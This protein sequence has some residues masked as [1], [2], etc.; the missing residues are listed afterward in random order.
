LKEEG[1]TGAQLQTLVEYADALS[2][3]GDWRGALE[4]IQRERA[5]NADVEKRSNDAV[6]KEMQS[7]Y[8]A[9]AKQRGIEILGRENAL[10]TAALAN[11]DLLQ[12]IGLII[13][14]VLAATLVLATV[15]YRRVRSTQS[16]LAQGHAKLKE[17]SERDPLTNLANRRRF[18]AL[19]QALHGPQSSQG[20]SGGLL[21]VD[22]DHFKRIN[23]GH[24]HAAGDQVLTE[25][26]KRLGLAVESD[27]LVV[28]W[29]GEE[30][31]VHATG[32]DAEQ[33]DRLAAR[34]L[35]ELGNTAVRVDGQALRI[36]ASVGHG[37]FPL[38]PARVP[39]SWEQAVNLCDMALYAAKGG[40]RNRSVGIVSV[41]VSESAQLRDIERDFEQARQAGRVT[42]RVGLG[43]AP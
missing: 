39:L 40:G 18:H 25:V 43:P 37:C 3:V 33:T 22:I 32:L 27:H 12:R 23:D 28:R 1:Q 24:G 14:V 38:P 6:S 9:E 26:A 10:K 20:F 7:R 42:V 41:D 2:A 31:L 29:G 13:A 4:I 11:R 16:A 17:A 30:F 5:L 36:T 15:L 34:V 21:L 35:H 19:M 8:D